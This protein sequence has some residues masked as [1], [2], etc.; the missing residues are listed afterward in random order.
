[1]PNTTSWIKKPCE[2]IETNFGLSHA[3]FV[4]WNPKVYQ[5]CAYFFL[6][7]FVPLLLLVWSACMPHLSVSNICHLLPF[8]LQAPV[9]T[10]TTNTAF[11]SPTT[12]Q[13]TALLQQPRVLLRLLLLTLELLMLPMLTM[14][15]CRRL[16]SLRALSCRKVVDLLLQVH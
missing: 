10:K 4:A 2:I 9:S 5:N 3:R 6:I 14:R 12:D 8:Q 16:S 15:T 7:F 1:M 13:L 11:L